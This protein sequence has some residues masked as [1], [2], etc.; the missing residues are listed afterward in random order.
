MDQLTLSW[1]RQRYVYG[2]VQPR[3]A[4]V[5]LREIPPSLV[6]ELGGVSAPRATGLAE[7]A[8]LLQQ[9]QAQQAV[10]AFRVGARVHHRKYG[11][12]I[13]LAVEGQGDDAKVTVSFNRFGKKKLLAGVAR[14]E[15]V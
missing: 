10:P 13:V 15:K 2:V 7:A 8:A 12:G 9:A 6:E 11:F 14:L 4:S 5:F 3:L 1:A